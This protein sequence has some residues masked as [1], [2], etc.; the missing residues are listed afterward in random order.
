[1]GGDLRAK[2]FENQLGVAVGD[3]RRLVE[4]GATFT[5]ANTAAMR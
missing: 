3:T 2:E 5:I 1:M 4:P